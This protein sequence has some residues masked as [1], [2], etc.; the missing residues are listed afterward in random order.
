MTGLSDG[1]KCAFFIALSLD[2]KA[3]RGGKTLIIV[4]DESSGFLASKVFTE[5]GLKTAVYPFRDFTFSDLASSHSYEHERLSVL[6]K[7]RSGG[8]DIYIT[9]PDAALQFTMPRQKFTETHA[10]HRNG[11]QFPYR[12]AYRKTM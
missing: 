11:R 7:I 12:N 2:Y 1:G 10:F 5:C 6:D 8:A 3:K 9:T 4:P